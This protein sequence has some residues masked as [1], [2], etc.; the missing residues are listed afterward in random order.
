[1]EKDIDLPGFAV[2]DTEYGLG[3]HYSDQGITCPYVSR[4][5]AVIRKVGNRYFIRDD[6]SGNG[7]TIERIAKIAQRLDKPPIFEPIEVEPGR[8]YEIFLGDRIRLGPF[9]DN[10]FPLYQLRVE[11]AASSVEEAGPRTGIVKYRGRLVELPSKGKAIIASDFHGDWDDFK[12]IEDKF[13]DAL[14]RG[15]S[16][17]L[18]ING[19]IL[20]RGPDSRKII[21]E[22]KRL[23]DKYRDN[24]H[25]IL[26]NHEWGY[27]GG[28]AYY[29]CEFE[30]EIDDS[31]RAF[32]KNC[33]IAVKTVNGLFIL[34]AGPS[35]HIKSLDD[36]IKPKDH[37][38]INGITW[39]DPSK[40][41]ANYCPNLHRTRG[42][43]VY[44]KE[45]GIEKYGDS[46]VNDFLQ[47]TGSKWLIT[48]HGH[49]TDL[50]VLPKQMMLSSSLTNRASSAQEAKKVFAE[51]DLSKDYKTK[52]ELK[53]DVKELK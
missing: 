29:P 23:K 45:N 1:M 9:A 16:E 14:R 27:V 32:L 47:K 28:L 39:N 44:A 20:D 30:M 53:K 10:R 51:V 46:A 24:V 18:I 37:K 40:E 35:S 12:K 2:E 36:I 38:Q 22:V 15:E 52:E 13:L 33:P 41:V 8:D 49:K 4:K 11:E 6:H 19:D 17:Y 48:G 43:E 42:D 5:H 25:L 50:D 31:D 7:T 26:G 34:H 21:N 3:R